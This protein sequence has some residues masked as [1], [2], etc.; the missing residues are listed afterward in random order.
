MYV[1]IGVH[2]TIPVRINICSNRCISG[3][4][5]SRPFTFTEFVSQSPLAPA[6]P[7]YTTNICT[8]IYMQACLVAG[9][10]FCG[11]GF[12]RLA[13]GVPV[14]VWHLHAGEEVGHYAVEQRHVKPQK[15]GQIDVDDRPAG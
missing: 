1:G 3:V 5:R 15:L 4:L 12:P 8:S 10:K 11:A 7:T 2:P 6:A 13:H 14:R 9:D